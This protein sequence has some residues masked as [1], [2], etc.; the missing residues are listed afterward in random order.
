MTTSAVPFVPRR[1]RLGRYAL[2]QAYDFTLNV[3]ILLVLVFVL[4]GVSFLMNMNAQEAFI[5]SRG[6]T[7]QLGQKLANFKQLMEM[8]TSVAPMIAMSGIVSTDRTSG[9]TRFLFAKPLS[10]TRYYA[11]SMI[12]KFVGYLVVAHLLIL[13]YSRYAPVPAYSYRAIAALGGVFLAVGGMLFLLSVITRFDGAVAILFLLISAISW[14]KWGQS[15]HPAR[16]LLYLVPPINK[17]GDILNWFIGMNGAG[18]IMEIPFPAKWFWWLT[19][20]GGACLL[21]GL[22]ILR[23]APLTKA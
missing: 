21:L 22:V 11:Q 19:G 4:L 23:R 17:I 16:V 3:A 10:P 2:W 18:T 13:L 5:Q 14:D 8:F 9:Y 6:G 20:Y 1:A 7:M 15:T 12:V